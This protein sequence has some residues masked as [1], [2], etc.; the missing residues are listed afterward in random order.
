MRAEVCVLNVPAFENQELATVAS[1]AKATVKA[2]SSENFM[3]RA[4]QDVFVNNRRLYCKEEKRNGY[5]SRV[6]G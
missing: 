6:C 5:H 1:A 3:M 2:V 4:V